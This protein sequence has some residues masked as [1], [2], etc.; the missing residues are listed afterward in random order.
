MKKWTK[1]DTKLGL[2]MIIWFPCW[3]LGGFL[4][5]TYYAFVES[6][7]DMKGVLDKWLAESK[8]APEK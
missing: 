5:F 8:Y 6:F 7:I 2:T 1:A 3:L 4:G